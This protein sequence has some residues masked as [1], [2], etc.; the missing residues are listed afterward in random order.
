VPPAVDIA[1][2][3]NE[4][5]TPAGEKICEILRQLTGIRSRITSVKVSA[6]PTL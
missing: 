3:T 6:D 2:T 5:V 1:R 4:R